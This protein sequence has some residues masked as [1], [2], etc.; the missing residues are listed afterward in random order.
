MGGVVLGASVGSGD[1]VDFGP[2]GSGNVGVGDVDR[3][4]LL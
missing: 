3:E 1:P 2:A 4:L